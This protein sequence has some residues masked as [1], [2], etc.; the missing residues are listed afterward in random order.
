[1]S[2]IKKAFEQADK[3]AV[4]KG[5]DKIYIFVDLHSTI[6]KPTYDKGIS[7]EFYPSA[8]KT[9]QQ[10]SKNSYY[11]LIMYT[12]STPE[13]TIIYNDLMKQND[14]NFD[15]INENPEVTNSGYGNYNHKPYFN[16]LLD[17][18]AGFDPLADWYEVYTST[19]Q[20]GLYIG[21]FQPFH[22]GHQSVINKIIDDGREP[23]ILIGSSNAEI[24]EKNPFIAHQRREMINLV[25]PN[26]RY[27]VI[28]D[29]DNNQDWIDR[30]ALVKEQV[31]GKVILYAHN[32]PS[33][34]GKYGLEKEQ[35]MSHLLEPHFQIKD[36]S[37]STPVPIS[38]TDIRNDLEANKHYLDERVYNYI[39]EL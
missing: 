38:A 27:G 28:N 1:M 34:A 26:I 20:Y 9:L 31:L 8:K 14:I 5:W 4:R 16:V 21:R 25:Y 36:I 10:M 12:C 6:L 2:S 18:K 13:D 35:F 19:K 23:L 7:T 24:S 32:K 37:D 39:K 3:D 15:Y 22:Y 30:I 29:Y 17:D 33:E 11:C